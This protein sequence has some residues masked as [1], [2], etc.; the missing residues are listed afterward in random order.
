MGREISR[1]KFLKIMSGTSL[2]GMSVL[3]SGCGRGEKETLGGKGWMPEQ[4]AG[5]G[6]WPVKVKGRIAIE[7]DNPSIMRDN[8]KCILCGQCIEACRDVI[9]VYGHFGLPLTTEVPCVNCG[10]CAM[11]CPTGA[12]TEKYNIKEVLEA[13]DDK[14][15][16][17]VVQTAPATKVSL[18]E[19]FGMEPG[20]II[21]GKQVAALRAV[22]FDAVLDTCFSA[23]LTIMEEA[24]ELFKRLQSGTEKMP[25]FTS[26]CP[27]W[28]KFC[29]YF[30]PEFQENL[31]TSKSPQQMMGAAIKTYY[32]AK[33]G[34][35]PKNI[36][37]VS[38]MP[39]TAKKF[40][41]QREE[42]NSSG[43]RDVDIVLTTREL[44]RLLKLK[45]IDFTNLPEEEYDS[46]LGESA[47]A[48]RIFG[49]TGGVME[50]AVR[51]LYYYVTK[52]N[53]P[54]ALLD[55]H[56]VRGL[57]S[58]KEASAQIPGFGEAR[59][60]VCHGLANARRVLADVK[61]NGSRWHFVEFMACPG[62]CIG[63]GGQPKSAMPLT[64]D[65]RTKRIAALYRSD[66]QAPKRSSH[67]N[68]EI[69]KIYTEFFGEPAGEKAEKYLHTHY[70]DRSAAIAPTKA[71]G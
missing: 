9:G 38:I 43:V 65:I 27:G 53:P 47:G 56:P 70:K 48:G 60:A 33:R 7:E 66:V 14:E 21:G 16:F 69:Q 59:I 42:M 4:Y 5:N 51:T 50:A 62:G 23:D 6:S 22:G 11:R 30:Y 34:I 64:D 35:D 39:C 36:V 31:S 58:V 12:I 24:M 18:G 52:Q 71:E 20:S 57:Q 25:Q 54:Q 1:R 3:A 17:V 63:G 61:Q 32:A 2:F 40:E 44:A 8:E 19:E 37:S 45:K 28:V 13:L 15:K 29:E 55:W 49:A 26:C 68:E 10:Q 41:A 46:I 67:E